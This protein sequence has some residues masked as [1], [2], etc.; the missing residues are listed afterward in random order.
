MSN[1]RVK[2]KRVQNNSSSFL[3]NPSSYL[4]FHSK[5]HPHLPMPQAPNLGT[6]L[7]SRC[8]TP[9]IHSDSQGLSISPLQHLSDTPPPVL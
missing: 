3:L 1:R 7:D 2:L 4:P 9:Y 6:L 5:V 8:L